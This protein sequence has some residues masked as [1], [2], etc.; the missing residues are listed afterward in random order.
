[1]KIIHHAPYLVFTFL[2]QKSY[3]TSCG[4]RSANV[5]NKSDEVTCQACLDDLEYWRK[6]AESMGLNDPLQPK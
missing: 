5:T 6:A 2:P 1:M 4:K 3:K